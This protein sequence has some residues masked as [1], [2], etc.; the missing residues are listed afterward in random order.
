MGVKVGG[1]APGVR[2]A[3][4][5][6]G[7]VGVVRSEAEVSILNFKFRWF[8]LLLASLVC[9]WASIGVSKV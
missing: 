1:A 2:A 9:G 8:L 4:G 7:A 5:S 3:S 6:C